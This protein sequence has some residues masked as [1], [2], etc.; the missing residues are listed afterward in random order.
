[1]SKDKKIKILIV[2][3]EKLI[4]NIL[5]LKLLDEGF[6]T[7]IIYNGKDAIK[8]LESE[9]FDLL[10]LD[11]IMPELSGFEVLEK[12]KE[13]NIKIPVFVAS[14]LSQVEDIRKVKNLGAVDFIVKSDTPVSEMVLKIKKYFKVT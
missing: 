11:L 12:L 7:K 8:R 6:D 5:S 2:E 9:N 3:N 14:S 10:I 4:A 13:K 1:M